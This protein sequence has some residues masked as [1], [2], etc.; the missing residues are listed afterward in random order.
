MKKILFVT[1]F[2]PNR[3]TAGQNYTRQLLNDL[4]QMYD[5]DLIYFKYNEHPLELNNN[6]HVLLAVSNSIWTK[7]ANI[8]KLLFIHPFFTARFNL[9][10]VRLLKRKSKDYDI[11]YF[12]FSQIFVYSLFVNHPHKI[13]MCHDI[14]TQKYLRYKNSGLNISFSFVKTSEKA[15]L[16]H[17]NE[18]FCFSQKDAELAKA[19]FNL[20]IEPVSFYIDKSLSELSYDDIEF[21]NSYVL[22]A[23]WNRKENEEGLKWFIENILPFIDN[24]N[25]LIM[26]P[27]LSEVIL[28][29]ISLYRNVKHMGF[30]DNPYSV[31]M[32][33]K[34]LLAPIFNGAGVKVKVIESL[35]TGTPVIG[36]NIAFEGIENIN[37]NNWK[38]LNLFNTAK[39]LIQLLNNFPSLEKKERIKLKSIFNM[40]YTS[41][42]LINKL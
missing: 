21:N 42:K 12:D 27:S 36:T 17:A 23:A 1:A 7:A 19:F 18:I 41:E 22:Y 24:T 15:L 8:L 28:K 25:I 10:I 38:A 9:S 37:L 33:S 4:S 30:V 26:G 35:A 3:L 40:T 34:A 6:I 2:P 16:K 31:L 13:M 5:I 20:K 14:I 32:Q 29:K 11:V 39:E